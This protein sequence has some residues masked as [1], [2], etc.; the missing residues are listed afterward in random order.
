MSKDYYNILGVSKSANDNEIK[1]AY[2][3]LALKYHPDKHKGDKDAEKK[4]KDI[5]EAYQVLSDK[6]KRSQYDQFGSA[7]FSGQGGFP[8]GFDF[9]GFQGGGSFSDIFES[10]FGGGGHARGGRQRG[11]VTGN[12]IEITMKLSFEEA[13]FGCQKDVEVTKPVRCD[14]CGGKGAEPGSR[15]IRCTSCDGT[16][17]IRSVKN[18]ILGQITTSQ[19][20]DSCHGEGKVPE[21]RCTACHGT[22]RIRAK[23][24]TRVKIPAGIDNGSTIRLSEKGEG[25]INGGP[26]GDLYVHVQ[27]IPSTKFVRSGCDVHGEKEVHLVQAVLG[28][29][30]NIETVHGNVKLKI[31]SGTQ[32]GKVFKITGKGIHRLHSSGNGDHYVKIKV[33]IPE[34]LSKKDRELWLELAQNAKIDP[35]GAKEGFLKGLF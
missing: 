10:F 24:T 22:T 23:E 27:I 9:S 5:N 6:Q 28:D 14:H 35:K 16:G 20:C 2:R 18:T 15:I 29:E 1:Q 32:S 8:G 25:G 7:G 26:S 31:P 30:I 19:I 4:F 3:K 33:N 12:D 21:K 34:K 13:A 17:E 11:P